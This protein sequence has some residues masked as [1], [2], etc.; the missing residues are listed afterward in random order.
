MALKISEFRGMAEIAFNSQPQLPDGP[1]LRVTN[2]AGAFTVG[3]DCRLIRIKG[4]GTITWPGVGTPEDFDGIE[5]RR[6]KAGDQF[7]VA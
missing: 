5:F 3:A 4:T 2:A 7:T 6:V 1:P